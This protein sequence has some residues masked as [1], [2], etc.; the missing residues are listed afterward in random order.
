MKRDKI[1]R[2]LEDRTGRYSS[3]EFIRAAET[4]AELLRGYATQADL[5]ITIGALAGR[6]TTLEATQGAEDDALA[7]RV[8]ALEQAH[9]QLAADLERRLGHVENVAVWLLAPYLAELDAAAAGGPEKVSPAPPRQPKPQTARAAEIARLLWEDPTRT[10]RSIAEA[11]GC[12][13]GNVG[14]HRHRLG[15]P[16][17]PPHK[18]KRNGGSAETSPAAEPVPQGRDTPD[19]HAVRAAALADAEALVRLRLAEDS[20]LDTATIGAIARETGVP[21]NVIERMGRQIRKPVRAT[22]PANAAGSPAE[23]TA[24]ARA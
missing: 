23:Q 10:D 7:R 19:T 17:N 3:Q 22:V 5:G 21:P 9:E 6:V 15:I 13:E 16:S 12:T 8:D 14:A 24:G 18:H 11:V 2:I 20:I 4:A 1:I